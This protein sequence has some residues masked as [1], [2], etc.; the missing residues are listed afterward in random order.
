VTA[1]LGLRSVSSPIVKELTMHH[2]TRR[3]F[4]R[5]RRF[6]ALRGGV[7]LGLVLSAAFAPVLARPAGAA[8]PGP[9]TYWTRCSLHLKVASVEVSPVEVLHMTCGQARRAIQ[10][11]RILLTPGG[12]IFTTQGLTC[13][14]TGIL[15][16]VDPSPNQ[17]P[18]A[19]RCTGAQQ[20]RLSFIWDW[21]S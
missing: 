4:P 7:L 2:R 12:P 3:R 14:S 20:R 10:R 13:R 21:A 19:E 5:R 18:A 9:V 16:R 8:S 1:E 15:P 17:L 11:A 6:T